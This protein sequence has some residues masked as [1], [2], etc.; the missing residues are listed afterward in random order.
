MSGGEGRALLNIGLFSE[1]VL[2]LC[3]P[4][5]LGIMALLLVVLENFGL[6][7]LAWMCLLY[8]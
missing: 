7:S 1:W 5:A 6:D 4:T 8:F 2:C 3:F